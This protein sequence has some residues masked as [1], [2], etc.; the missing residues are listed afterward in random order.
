MG[1]RPA[2]KLIPEHSNVGISESATDSMNFE[3]NKRLE[4]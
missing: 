2:R 3:I 1:R 4:K